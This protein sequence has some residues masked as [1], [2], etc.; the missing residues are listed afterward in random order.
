MESAKIDNVREL[1]RNVLYNYAVYQTLYQWLNSKALIELTE[2][3]F[4]VNTCNNSLQMAIITWCKV[5]G[6]KKNKNT[7]YTQFIDR[8]TLS[9]KTNEA[10]IDFVQCVKA[11]KE[12]RD[13]YIAHTEDKPASV[14][15][16]KDAVLITGIFDDLTRS[17]NSV[18]LIEWYNIIREDLADFLET[19]IRT[20]TVPD[21]SKFDL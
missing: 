11:I 6:S 19:K 12:F 10:G 17:E 3:R 2:N 9:N 8:K 1:L 15:Y 21:A 4:W 20:V 18:P 5:F 7:Y 14:P 13:K 16:F